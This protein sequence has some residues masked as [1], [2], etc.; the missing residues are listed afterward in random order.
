MAPKSLVTDVEKFV[1]D[2]FSRHPAQMVAERKVIHDPI[3]G[4]NAFEPHEIALIDLPFCQRLRRISQTDVASLIYPS[5]NHNR[6][7]HSLG[8]A[9]IAG[10]ILDSLRQRLWPGKTDILSSAAVMEVR[11]AAILHDIGQGPF[12]HLTDY[13]MKQLPEVIRYR[14]K[15]PNKF[16]EDKP[17][18]MLSYLIVKSPTFQDYV[19]HE[20]VGKYA[21][22]EINIDRIAEMIV[23]AGERDPLNAWQ[24][25][26]INGP[27]DADKLD[28]LQRDAYF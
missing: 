3:L 19:K 16:S 9:T 20:I 7:E 14:K 22:P 27:F 17:H 2:L 26:I 12:S 18:E 11:T 8:V 28:Y 5:A 10:K 23:A 13:I 24:G 15:N 1:K 25:N 4:T 21:R 6:L